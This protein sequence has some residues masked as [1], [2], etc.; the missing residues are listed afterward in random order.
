M[1][2]LRQYYHSIV[3]PAAKDTEWKVKGEAFGMGVHDGSNRRFEDVNAFHAELGDFRMKIKALKSWLEDARAQ[4]LIRQTARLREDPDRLK[5]QN[6]PSAATAN[7]VGASS[8]SR[9]IHKQL[10]KQCNCTIEEACVKSK[11]LQATSRDAEVC[12]ESRECS[13]E[14]CSID[15]FSTADEVG[16]P[17]PGTSTVSMDGSVSGDDPRLQQFHELW[18]DIWLS[19][20]ELSGCRCNRPSSLGLLRKVCLDHHSMNT[21]ATCT[22]SGRPVS[23]GE[24]K[25][26]GICNSTCSDQVSK[27][28]FMGTDEDHKC[29]QKGSHIHSSSEACQENPTVC[30]TTPMLSFDGNEQQWEW[31]VH[32]ILEIQDCIRLRNAKLSERR[33]RMGS[34]PRQ[35]QVFEMV[36]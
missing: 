4:P 19:K 18:D 29:S 2:M 16:S 14:Q 20:A 36:D 24:Q 35:R 11:A 30:G 17:M 34:T 23:E 27:I 5:A 15:D 10:L 33:S 26:H 12:G 22:S 32:R 3:L 9:Q 7:V 31:R 8:N 6:S 1:P 13:S 28:D 21:T 25:C